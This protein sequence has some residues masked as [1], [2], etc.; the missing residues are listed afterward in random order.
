MKQPSLDVLMKY[1]DCKYTLVIAAAKRA[2]ALM[3]NSNSEE[4]KDIKPVSL[5]L[6][7]IGEGK[8]DVDFSGESVKNDVKE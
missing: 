8:I 2:R 3:A 5:A 6:N 7:E 4:F 1:V